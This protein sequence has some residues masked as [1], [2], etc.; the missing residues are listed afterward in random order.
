MGDKL[1]VYLTPSDIVINQD[2]LQGVHIERL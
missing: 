2:V 1:T